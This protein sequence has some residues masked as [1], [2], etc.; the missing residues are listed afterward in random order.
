MAPSLLGR[1]D[2]NDTDFGVKGV[3]V[4]IGNAGVAIYLFA[5]HQMSVSLS[6]T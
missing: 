4:V 3:F 2:T 1:S 5:S 6:N